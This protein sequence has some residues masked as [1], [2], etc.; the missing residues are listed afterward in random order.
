VLL[1]HTSHCLCRQY[2][3]F[4]FSIYLTVLDSII[5]VSLHTKSQYG[6]PETWYCIL[7]TYISFIFLASKYIK[8]SKQDSFFLQDGPINKVTSFYDMFYFVSESVL[9]AINKNKL[10]TGL[11]MASD[12]MLLILYQFST[13]RKSRYSLVLIKL[14][15]Q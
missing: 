13:F 2:F 8:A 12:C 11:C 7:I 10:P 14:L 3:I 15:V 6:L 4:I 9:H 1:A 5:Y